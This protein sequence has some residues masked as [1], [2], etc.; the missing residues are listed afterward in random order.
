MTAPLSFIYA[1]SDGTNYALL[2][3]NLTIAKILTQPAL[4]KR[5]QAVDKAKCRTRLVF[6]LKYAPSLPLPPAG[7]ATGAQRIASVVKTDELKQ[8]S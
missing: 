2:T 5:R 4:E 8:M 6:E 1:H 3:V 7:S